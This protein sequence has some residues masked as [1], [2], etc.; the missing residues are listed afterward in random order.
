MSGWHVVRARARLADT[1]VAAAATILG[2]LCL[3]P[4]FSA[5]SWLLPAIVIVVVIAATGAGCRAIALPIPLVPIAELLGLVGTVTVMYAA[6][7]AWAKVVPTSQAGD[8][9][10]QLISTGMADAEAYAAPVPMLPQLMLLTVG[11]AGLVALCIDTLYVSVRSPILAGLPLLFLYLWS[12]IVLFGQAPWWQFAPAAVGWLLLLAADQRERIR[13]WGGLASTSRV[14]GLS[15]AA[16]RAGGLAVA[17]AVLAGVVIPVRALSPL[18]GGGG[19]GGG[20]T[21]VAVGPV[22]LDPLV[23]MRRNLLEATDTEVLR[24]RTNNP[25]P[26]YMRVTALEDFDGV[27]WQARPALAQGRIGGMPLPGNVI[28]RLSVALPEYHVRGGSS[29]SYLFAITSLQNS[30]LPLPYPITDLE[31]LSGLRSDW[32][33]DPQTGIAY[34]EDK[35]ATGLK[36]GVNALDPDVRPVELRSATT[37]LGQLWPQLS[38]PNGVSPQVKQL[39]VKVTA[40]AT[41]PYDAAVALQKWFTHDGGFRYS[42]S[43]R[44]GADADYL[45]EF[46]NDKVG[47]CEQF[48]ATMALMARTLGIPS[49]VVVGFTQGKQD[50]KGTWIVTVRD[51]HAWPELWFDGIGWMRFE[52]TPRVDATVQSPAYAPSEAGGEPNDVDLRK[53]RN[54]ENDVPLQGAPTSSSRGLTG[55]PGLVAL[56]ILLMVL[57]GLVVPAILRMVRRRR[58][59][60]ARSYVD[61]VRGAWDEVADTAF[62][63]G[64][65]WSA[66]STPR[67]CG[68]RLSRG[69]PAPAAEALRRLR[70]QVEQVRYGRAPMPGIDAA[71]QSERS[72]AVRADVKAVSDELRDRV[73]WQTRMVSYCWP[74][75]VR[76]RQRS[77][78]RSMKPGDFGGSGADGLAAA[79]SAGRAPNAE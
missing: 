36:Y 72:A 11:G 24:Y 39:A 52:P 56:A 50:A 15:P 27:T 14:S 65:P 8:V 43:V 22:I 3:I 6:D 7:E 18:L 42:T 21:E 2:L 69:M 49:R 34:S 23:S 71:A 41:T 25:K 32:R 74:P 47:Y 13:E 40:G 44:S 59:L 30:F 63:L 46:L 45:M 60:H 53:L 77:S 55:V 17:L 1:V 70:V 10:R 73:R 79:S 64:Q 4:L 38:V 67:Q 12:A 29:Y 48:A 58:R 51:A 26:P 75:S 35:P 76:R 78:S 33:L 57:V 31:D 20:A 37:P 54:L 61:V 5:T 19:T 68:D 16:R 66:Y 62:D 28:D 9:L